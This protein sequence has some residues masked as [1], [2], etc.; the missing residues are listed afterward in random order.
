M[1]QMASSRY[2][3]SL[4][5]QKPDTI[6][7]RE[8]EQPEK[9]HAAENHSNLKLEVVNRTYTSYGKFRKFLIMAR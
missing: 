1:K 8:E 2:T 7:T 9:Q 4:T 5:G 6:D 3:E